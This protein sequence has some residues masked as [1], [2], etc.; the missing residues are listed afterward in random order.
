M[1]SKQITALIERLNRLAEQRKGL[2]DQLWTM[3][4]ETEKLRLKLMQLLKNE[5]NNGKDL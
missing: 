4:N 5:D 2:L 1:S 3:E